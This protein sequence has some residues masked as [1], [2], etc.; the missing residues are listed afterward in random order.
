MPDRAVVMRCRTR[1]DGCTRPGSDGYAYEY[2]AD[3]DGE[4]RGARVMAMS[5]SGRAVASDGRVTVV[6]SQ[7][8]AAE[9]LDRALERIYELAARA[10]SI[11]GFDPGDE[12]AAKALD[13]LLG[14]AQLI[15]DLH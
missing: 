14:W 7:E 8:Q 4:H 3:E 15:E 6:L 12:D 11:S 1:E 10:G 9:L 2:W 5:T 13:E